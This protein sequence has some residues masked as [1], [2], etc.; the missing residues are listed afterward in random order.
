[1]NDTYGKRKVPLNTNAIFHSI[2][3]VKKNTIWGT[4]EWQQDATF[5]IGKDI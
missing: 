5:Y 2:L 4:H 1:M 3:L